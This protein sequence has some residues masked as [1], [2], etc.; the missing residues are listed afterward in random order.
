MIPVVIDTGVLVS[1]IFWRREPHQ[2]VRAWVQG[3]AAMVVSVPI[4]TEYDR[5]LRELKAEQHFTTDLEPWLATIRR[6]ALWVEP[7]PLGRRVCRDPK[8]DMFIEAALA[9][10]ARLVIARDPD[11]T[12]LEKPF[13]VEMVTPRQFLARLPRQ[14]RRELE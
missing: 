2:C 10:G 9:G 12:D 1:G 8:D 3:L 11:L 5:V 7:S 6:T 4:F 13:G 14:V